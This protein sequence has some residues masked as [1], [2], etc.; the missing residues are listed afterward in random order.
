MNV[1]VSFSAD[2]N[3]LAP[4][5]DPFM[6][7]LSV[8]DAPLK[9]LDAVEVSMVDVVV[10]HLTVDVS[11]SSPA[12]NDVNDPVLSSADAHRCGLVPC[13]ESLMVIDFVD[14][15]A[16]ADGT[17]FIVNVTVSESV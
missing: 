10:Y 12:L 8:P 5:A 15:S 2:V 4:S 13:A 3:V 1:P 6:A 7:A 16:G 9:K 11:Q 14:R 17:A